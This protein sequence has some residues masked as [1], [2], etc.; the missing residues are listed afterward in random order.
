[1]TAQRSPL[2]GAHESLG[3][4]FVNFG[5]WEMPLS[6]TGVLDEHQ[7][8]HSLFPLFWDMKEFAPIAAEFDRLFATVKT[9][10]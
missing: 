4:R 2:A 10:A 3:A 5:G 1:M 9:D 6:Y 8:R 7:L